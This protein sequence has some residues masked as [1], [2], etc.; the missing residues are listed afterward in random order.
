[1]I[2]PMGTVFIVQSF[3]A[4]LVGASDRDATPRFAWY[5]LVIAARRRRRSPCAL[6]PAIDPLLALA[7]FS[8]AVREPDVR[9][10]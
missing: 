2:L 1:M 5:G 10:T 6:I 4:Q 8:P 9:A 3:V 7:D